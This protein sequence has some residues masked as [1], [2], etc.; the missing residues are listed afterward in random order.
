MFPGEEARTFRAV[1][2]SYRFHR[3]PVRRLEVSSA[4]RRLGRVL[5]ALACCL[6]CAAALAADLDG[7][8]VP[9]AL[10]NCPSVFNPD[11]ADHDLDGRGD[12]CDPDDDDDLVPDGSDNCPLVANPDQADSDQDGTGDACDAC[13]LDADGDFVC[14]DADNCPGTPNTDQANA[15]GDPVG[16]ACDCAPGD[17]A[18]FARAAPVG[19]G[20]VVQ[21][22]RVTIAW[23]GATD[24]RSYALYKGRIPARQAFSYRHTC[25]ARDL[26]APEARDDRTP[27]P[28]ETFYYLA[29][30][31]NCFGESDL[32]L[33]A[34]GATRPGPDGCPDADADG[35][36]D[37]LDVCP[38]PATRRRRTA[39]ATRSATFAT[40]ARTTR[41][42]TSTPTGS[43]P[44]ATTARSS[45]MPARRTATRTAPA[46]RATSA[47][48]TP[49]TTPTPTGCAP[50]PTT[51][52]RSRTPT[53]PMPTTTAWAI[54]ATSA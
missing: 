39:T 40:P 41:R 35:I 49:R 4:A 46:T 22:D 24:A 5:L 32:G 17:G 23:P 38:R 6:G 9:N 25:F 14:D 43:A 50:T 18:V 29:A 15:D 3:P 36:A 47:R 20:L 33:D 30:A 2:G 19:P 45:R 54:S 8:G 13:A 11:Q 53:R 16:D 7:D 31:A 42:T 10:D 44:R 26:A 12:A 27:V 1:R 21:A 37:L 52:P 48:W 34:A 28:G 51:A